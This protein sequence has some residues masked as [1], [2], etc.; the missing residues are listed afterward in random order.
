MKNLIPVS[1]AVIITLA[2]FSCHKDHDAGPTSLVGNWAVVTDS[3]YNT[4][5]G[6]S[7]PP[8]IKKYI[9]TAADHFDFTSNGKLYAR[10]GTFLVDTADYTITTDNLTNEQKINLQYSYIYSYG[11]TS[12][13]GS[14]SFDI[15]TLTDHSL[16]LTNNVITPGGA[17][18]ETLTLQK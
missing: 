11:S 17:F 8:S 7:G 18:Y 10:E 13:S 9:G 4:G 1:L 2:L 6:T 16:V 14:S 3:T 15:R 12:K 5:I